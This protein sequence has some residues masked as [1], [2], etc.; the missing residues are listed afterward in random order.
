M[1]VA[2]SMTV[3]C[4]SLILCSPCKLRM[5]LLLLCF[6]FEGCISFQI[7]SKL[8]VLNTQIQ[9]KL[10]VLNTF[11]KFRT[12]TIFVTFYL[13]ATRSR[14]PNSIYLAQITHQISQLLDRQTDSIDMVAMYF[15]N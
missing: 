3:F 10:N 15:T 12:V 5:L 4:S 14:E 8:N 9:S 2:S 7:Q 13:Q 6:I 1:C 11:P